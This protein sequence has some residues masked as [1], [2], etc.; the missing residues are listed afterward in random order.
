MRWDLLM[1]R[2]GPQPA[3]YRLTDLGLQVSFFPHH[4]CDKSRDL[5]DLFLSRP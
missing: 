3:L 1:N 4:K 5:G 2:G